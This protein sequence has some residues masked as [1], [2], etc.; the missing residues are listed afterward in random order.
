MSGA[1]CGAR[2]AWTQLLLYF[3]AR[4]SSWQALQAAPSE[5]TAVLMLSGLPPLTVASNFSA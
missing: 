2:V 4:K 1:R 3:S 5:P